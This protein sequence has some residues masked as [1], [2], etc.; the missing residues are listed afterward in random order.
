MGGA[1]HLMTAAP[2]GAASTLG[3]LAVRFGCALQGDS[4][5]RVTHVSSLEE[6]S[7]DSVAFIANAKYRR[8]LPTTRAGVVILEPSLAEQCPV[9]ALLTKNP[10]AVFARIAALLHPLAQAEPGVHASAVVDAAAKIDPSAAI[11]P[12]CVIGANVRIG[13]RVVLG[14]SCIVLRD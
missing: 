10:Y 8:Y 12:H 4:D 7:S 2:H 5:A 13:A 6:A 9:P 3:E 11:G 1:I 14:P